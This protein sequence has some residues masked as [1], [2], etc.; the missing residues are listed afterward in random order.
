MHIPSVDQIQQRKHN[1]VGSDMLTSMVL[2]RQHNR[3]L[4]IVVTVQLFFNLSIDKS[5][6]DVAMLPLLDEHALPRIKRD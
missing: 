5:M 1:C 4:R 2:P 6:S 3:W